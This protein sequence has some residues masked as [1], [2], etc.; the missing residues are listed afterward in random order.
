MSSLF[1]VTNWVAAER[2]LD[3]LGPFAHLWS[4]AIEEQFYVLW[5]LALILLLRR[6]PVRS[7]GRIATFAAGCVFLEVAVRSFSTS[8]VSL[9]I[10]TAGQGMAF[11]SWARPCSA[12][13][14][15]P[16]FRRLVVR[17]LVQ[18]WG[19]WAVLPIVPFVICYNHGHDTLFITVACSCRSTCAWRC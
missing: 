4:M 2:G 5:P 11:L 10:G 18:R 17:P 14:A 16:R 19:V 9:H 12:V 8:E 6:M 15:R 7:A 13:P 1:Y 3:S